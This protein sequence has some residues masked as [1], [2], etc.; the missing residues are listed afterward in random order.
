MTILIFLMTDM[1]AYGSKLRRRI[2]HDTL[3]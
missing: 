2:Q 1:E 3:C